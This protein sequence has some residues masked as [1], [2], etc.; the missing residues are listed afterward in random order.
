[1]LT[2][3]WLIVALVVAIALMIFMISKLN[4]HRFCQCLL[5]RFF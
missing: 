1:M 4:I 2:G 5:S 3:I